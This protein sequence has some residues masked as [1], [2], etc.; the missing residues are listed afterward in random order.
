MN[1]YNYDPE[2]NQ[3]TSAAVADE[4]PLEPGVYLIPAYATEIAPPTAG[5]DEA[6]FWT[7][8][9]W[10][11]KSTIPEPEPEPPAKVWQEDEVWERIRMHRDVWL[12]MCDWTQGADA[13]ISAEKVAEYVTYRTQLRD[14]PNTLTLAQATEMCEQESTMQ[15]HSLWPT[16]PS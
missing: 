10:E 5:E 6:P 13:P 7:G 16:K 12:R 2:T 4:S 11:V 14:L 9:A 8:T 1:I 3:Y 15:S